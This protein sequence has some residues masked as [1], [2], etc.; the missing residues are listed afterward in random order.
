MLFED[1]LYTM[2]HIT[3]IWINAKHAINE[4]GLQIQGA[5]LS[6]TNTLKNKKITLFFSNSNI[7][8]FFMSCKY[9]V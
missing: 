8:S 5:N 2:V 3:E 1:A 6:I 7:I 9:V 4:G